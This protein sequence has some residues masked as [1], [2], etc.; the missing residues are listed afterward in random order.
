MTNQI[1]LRLPTVTLDG[2]TYFIDKSLNQLR[3][4]E[5][6]HDFMDFRNEYDMQDY[7]DEHRGI[8]QIQ[9]ALL[10]TYKHGNRNNIEVIATS[11]D[12]SALMNI[13]DAINAVNEKL[14]GKDRDIL[15]VDVEKLIDNYLCSVDIV[16]EMTGFVYDITICGIFKIKEF[17]IPIT[18]TCPKC[19]KILF[20]G[21]EKQAKRLIIYCVECSQI[22]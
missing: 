13:R 20:K 8:K 1:P 19:K 12:C 4:V 17:D 16:D 9:Y 2:K 21:T 15:N 18:I 22:S 11:D 5:T 14:E 3:N 6:P 10:G 7:I